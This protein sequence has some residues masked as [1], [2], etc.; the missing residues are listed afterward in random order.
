MLVAVLIFCATATLLAAVLIAASI[1][2]A[3]WPDSNVRYLTLPTVG[4]AAMALLLAGATG[5]LAAT[6]FIYGRR[7]TL[8]AE[9][10]DAAAEGMRRRSPRDTR[11]RL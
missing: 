5:A 3:F 10:M 1:A 4:V 8:D 9:S 11:V 7:N 6:A 2:A